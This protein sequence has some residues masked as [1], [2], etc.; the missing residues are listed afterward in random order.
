MVQAKLALDCIAYE[1]KSVGRGEVI[2]KRSGSQEVRRMQAVPPPQN[3]G[4]QIVV[5]LAR[6][7]AT[8]PSCGDGWLRKR[9]LGRR[10]SRR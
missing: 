2:C 9:W 4:Q 1:E 7:S 5:Q 6:R 8:R 3:N 10:G